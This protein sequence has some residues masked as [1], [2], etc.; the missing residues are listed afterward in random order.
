M[1]VGDFSMKKH[2]HRN[3]TI[4]DVARV[5]RVGRMTVSRVINDSPA[6]RPST[7]RRVLSAIAQLGYQQNEAARM[8]QGKRAKMIGLI[9]PDLS[10]AFFASC[11]HTVQHIAHDHGYMTLVASSERDIEAE[12]A[13]AQLMATRKLSG[14]LVVTSTQGGDERLSRLQKTGLPI[15]AFDRP[16]EGIQTDCVV[17]ENRQGAE[18]ASQHL[19]EHGHRNIAC[20]GYDETTYTTMERVGGYLN[21]MRAANHKPNVVVDLDTFEKLRRWVAK[22]CKGSGRTTA[23][24]SLN[25]VLSIWILRAL[26]ELGLSVPDDVALIGFDDF[27][28]APLI[29]TPL[30]TVAQSPVAIAS[31]AITLLLDRINRAGT[32]TDVAKIVLPMTLIV[33]NSCGCGRPQG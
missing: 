2:D 18:M 6:V 5:A 13:H 15:V 19:I 22:A 11:A 28:L 10:D 32:Q 8:L 21:V 1:V 12:V 14:I 31:R 24:F 16:I 26:A 23:I 30:T 4:L 9:V 33:R 20:I 7:R 25:A 17:V 3:P 29:S 27:E